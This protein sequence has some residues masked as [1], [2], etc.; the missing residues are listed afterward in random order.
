M[1]RLRVI[2]PAVTAS[3][4]IEVSADV[5][6]K[7]LAQVV[8]HWMSIQTNNHYVST[9]ETLLV[10]AFDGALLQ[11]QMTLEELHVISNEYFYLF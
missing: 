8:S 9:Q 1:I 2:A 11:N 10:R 6:T 7:E 3:M 4:D 5:T